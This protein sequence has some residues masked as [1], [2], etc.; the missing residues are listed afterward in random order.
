MDEVSFPGHLLEIRGETE[1]ALL[2][3][4]SVEQADHGGP[5]DID[6]GP[7]LGLRRGRHVIGDDIVAPDQESGGPAR[8]DETRSCNA[9]GL[10]GHGCSPRLNAS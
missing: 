3:L 5:G 9:D 1:L 10:D 4:R 7:E 6:G 8:P 2:H